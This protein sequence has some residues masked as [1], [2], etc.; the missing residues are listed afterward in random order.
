M[1]LARKPARKRAAVIG[2]GMAGASCAR[3]MADAGLDVQVFD[4]SRGVGGRMSTRRASWTSADGAERRAQFDHGAPGFAAQEPEFVRL[5]EQ[6]GRDGLSSRWV[7]R[8]AP[9]SSALLDESG[10]WVPTPDMP[11]L[12]R[13]LLSGLPVHTGCTVDA[14][15]YGPAGWTLES[16][17]STVGEGFD[18][19]VIAIPPQQAAILLR[20]HQAEWARR[21]EALPMLPGWALMAVTD[22]PVPAPAWDLAWPTSGPLAWVV[23]NDAKPGRE[24]VPGLAH[25]VVHATAPWSQKHLE[26]P[27]AEVQ[28]AL[29][30]A[31]A[32]WLG[33]SV[34][35]HHAAVHRW[36]FASAP[37]ATRASAPPAP[38]A[39][40]RC[41]WDASSGLG[42]CGD[43]LGG[44]GVEDAWCSARALAA[45]ITDQRPGSQAQ[46]RVASSPLAYR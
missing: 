42:V 28:G 5:V 19:V 36:R 1:N 8:V 26:T 16:T 38:V 34:V 22:D 18:T 20:P 37:R 6:A 43:A 23:R 10:L 35:W 27:A 46:A 2:A 21:A 13:A 12:C 30:D 24:R 14:L 33:R 45:F 25:W 3:Q 11:A 31:L 4:K 15:R 44:A 39:S 17:G 9:G 32:A 29:Q 40:G 41:W 7:P